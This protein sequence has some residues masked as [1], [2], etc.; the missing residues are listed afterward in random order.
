MRRALAV[1][2]GALAE[3]RR[4]SPVER[5]REER[6]F[7]PAALE[8]LETPASPLGRTAAALICSLFCLAAAWSWFG[9]IDTVAVAQ[10]RIVPG[11]RVKLI[12]PVEVGVVREI[13]VRDGQRVRAGDPL[14]DLDPTESEVDL[15]QTRRVLEESR[16]E[17]ARA[18]Y[19][20]VVDEAGVLDAAA[21]E[22]LRAE[23]A[24]G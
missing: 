22:A 21:T 7:L 13:H 1:W 11:G 17:Y 5:T 19:G 3:E 4:R 2:R 16:M 15:E 8:V 10:G 12:Q 6:E 18:E 23:M 9:H 14:V 20:V 24:A